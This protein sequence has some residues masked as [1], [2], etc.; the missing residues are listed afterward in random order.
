LGTGTDLQYRW[1]ELSRLTAVVNAVS[2]DSVQYFYDANDRLAKRMTNG[3]MDRYWV[4]NGDALVAELGAGL[5]S[6]Y[7]Y[8]DAGV[9]APMLGKYADAMGTLQGMYA[10]GDARGDVLGWMNQTGTAVQTVQYDSW[11]TPS[12]SGSVSSARLWKGLLWE[13]GS[14][15]GGGTHGLYYMRA[16]WYDSELGRFLSEDPIGITGGLNLYAFAGN[17]PINGR[18]PFGSCPPVDQNPYDCPGKMGALVM[19]GQMAPSINHEV[20]WFLPKNIINALGGNLLEA[21]LAKLAGAFAGETGLLATS[22]TSRVIG[23]YPEYIQ[24]GEQIGAKTFSVPM[25]V[26]RAMSTDA[27]WAAN[28]KFLDRGINEGAAFILAVGEDG[29]NAGSTLEREIDYLVEHN[30]VWDQSHTQLIPNSHVP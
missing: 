24:L 28:V 30:Y 21:G 20:A 13:G 26:W 2:H 23:H 15:Q 9:D 29:I 3:V 25:N 19:L 6:K 14:A 16:R 12:V 22:V 4:W 18:D 7:I 27:Q 10:V 8:A 17:D 1:D 11:G 5:A